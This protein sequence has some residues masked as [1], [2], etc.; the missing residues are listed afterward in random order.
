MPPQ[1]FVIVDGVRG[2]LDDFVGYRFALVAK[3]NPAKT[4]SQEQ[5]AFLRRLDCRL[6]TLADDASLD[7][8][9]L[10]D[11]DGFYG[12][13]LSEKEAFAML[14]RPDTNLF[15]FAPD[16]SKLSPLVEELQRKLHWLA[17]G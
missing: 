17:T 5:V 2:R 9:R 1:G 10:G 12:A 15:G 13:Y 8:R 14:T 4:L 3:T 7:A 11:P 16:A 6:F